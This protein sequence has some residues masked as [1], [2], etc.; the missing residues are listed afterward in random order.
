MKR[1]PVKLLVNHWRSASS[2]AAL[3]FFI[4]CRLAGPPWS[5][6]GFACLI[7][8]LVFLAYNQRAWLRLRWDGLF[9]KNRLADE[10]RIEGDTAVAAVAMDSTEGDQQVAAQLA[11][12]STNAQRLTELLAGGGLTP[13][14]RLDTELLLRQTRRNIERVT[15]AESK[16]HAKATGYIPAFAMPAVSSLAPLLLAFGIPAAFA[17]VEVFRANHEHALAERATETAE[18]NASVA[19]ILNDRLTAATMRLQADRDQ[20][21]MTAANI[22]RERLISAHFAARERE[23]QRAIQNTLTGGPAPAWS[24]R[25]DADPTPGA[26]GGNANAAPDHSE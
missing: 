5:Y 14:Q 17:G 25:D 13:Q 8:W 20:A 4:V 23:R 22:E 26:A 16:R 24:L 3:L 18:H 15:K 19:S 12:W 9:H 21:A 2:A 7:G 6:L 10:A 1:F 11:A